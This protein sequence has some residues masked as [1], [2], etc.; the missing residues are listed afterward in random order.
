LWCFSK[1]LDSAAVA[2]RVRCSQVLSAFTQKRPTPPL[3]STKRYS[4]RERYYLTLRKPLPVV[5]LQTPNSM[6]GESLQ[7]MSRHASRAESAWFSCRTLCVE[8][9][10]VKSS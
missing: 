5:V 4:E 1:K 9:S 6:V 3:R 8:T 10:Q 2:S 7:K